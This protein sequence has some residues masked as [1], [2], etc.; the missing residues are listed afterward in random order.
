[1]SGELKNR[2]G[3]VFWSDQCAD[4]VAAINFALDDIED[5]YERTDFLA[6]WREGDIA[7]WPEFLKKVNGS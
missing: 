6:S 7:P 4:A 5:T 2:K 3:E 1:M